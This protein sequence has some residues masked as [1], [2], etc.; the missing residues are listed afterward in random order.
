VQ[1]PRLVF[2][3]QDGLLW[4]TAAPFEFRVGTAAAAM[5]LVR[6]EHRRQPATGILIDAQAVT[7]RISLV[8]RALFAV[9]VAGLHFH[10]PIAM[11]ASEVVIHP[12]RF[13]QQ[14]ARGLGLNLVVFTAAV[15]ASDWLVHRHGKHPGGGAAEVP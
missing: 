13:G 10:V 11:V 2:T 4:V 6:A 7:G 15:D 5:R 1:A 12:D 9:Y 3:R 14:V 8:D